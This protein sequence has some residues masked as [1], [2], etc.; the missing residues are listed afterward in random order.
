MLRLQSLNPRRIDRKT[1]VLRQTIAS[2]RSLQEVEMASGIQDLEWFARESLLTGL[3]KP[4]IRK[5]ML[6]AGWTEVDQVRNAIDAYADATFPVAI[7]KPRPQLSTRDAFLYLVLFTTL[8][9][10]G[11]NLGSLIFPVA[12]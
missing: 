12:Q 4:E 5:A 11:Y 8:Y 2:D 9:V 7:R 1:N 6:E 10:S 3:G